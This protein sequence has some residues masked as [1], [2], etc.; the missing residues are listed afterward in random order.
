MVQSLVPKKV[1]FKCNKRCFLSKDHIASKLLNHSRQKST[2]WKGIM[3]I[4]EIS[5]FGYNHIGTLYSWTAGSTPKYGFHPTSSQWQNKAFLWHPLYY[6]PRENRWFQHSC[7]GKLFMLFD[8][9]LILK[10]HY[11]YNYHCI[12]NHIP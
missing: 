12:C 9:E 4:S 11:K 5:S 1:F 3:I 2:T 8:P 6:S 7:L 10:F